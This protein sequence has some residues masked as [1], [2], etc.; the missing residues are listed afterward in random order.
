MGILMKVIIQTNMTKYRNKH[1]FALSDVVVWQPVEVLT[2]HDSV[3]I[4]TMP[5]STCKQ[6][7]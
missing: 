3:I 7:V 4:M 5:K 6:I 2:P 1:S